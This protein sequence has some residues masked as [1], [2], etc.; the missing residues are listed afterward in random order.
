V[1]DTERARRTSRVAT[2]SLNL[3]AVVADVDLGGITVRTWTYGGELPGPEIRMK[4]GDVLHARLSNALPRP[5]TVHWHGIA[6]RNDM[7]G[8]G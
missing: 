8:F 4:R 1:A 7:G 3:N 2:A 6:L 5:T